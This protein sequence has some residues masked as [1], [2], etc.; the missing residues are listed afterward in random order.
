MKDKKYNIKYISL[1]GIVRGGKRSVKPFLC[2]LIE[3]KIW[4]ELWDFLFHY[5]SF[6]FLVPSGLKSKNWD[7]TDKK[8][9]KPKS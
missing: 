7:A 6:G 9:E 1:F 3:E 5:R 4:S 8:Y 2:N